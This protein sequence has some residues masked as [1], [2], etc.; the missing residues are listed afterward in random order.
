MDMDD[1]QCVTIY[2]DGGCAPNPGPGGYGVVP[3]YGAH[4]RELSA[5][6]LVTTNNCMELLA[7]VVG[8]RALTRR[9]RVL[10]Y[11]DSTYIVDAM[12][13]GWPR[14]WAAN[15]WKR[16]EKKAA[17]NSDLWAELL[18]LCDAHEVAFVWVKGHAGDPDNERCD[19]LAAAATR[20]ATLLTDAGY[21][22]PP[23]SPLFDAT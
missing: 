8:L 20:G 6:Y 7:T 12:N 22:M 23:V 10:L 9:C 17:A 14:R 18:R 15:E 21:G 5:G 4:R 16:S 3:R 11:S 13:G 1:L 2:T 19:R